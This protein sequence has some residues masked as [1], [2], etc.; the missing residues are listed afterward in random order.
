MEAGQGWSLRE[1]VIAVGVSLGA[2]FVLVELTK[3]N[4]N[5]LASQAIYTALALLL[6]SIFGSTGVALARLQPRSAL[7]GAVTAILS[8]LALGATVVSFWSGSRSLFGF[9]FEGTGGTVGGITV[10]LTIAASAICV[11]LATARPGEDSGT[12]LVRAG[13]ISAL[14]IFVGLA[15]LSILVDSVDIG[16]RVY[17]II[18]TVYIATTVVSLLLR[19][20]PT[21][22]DP[23]PVQ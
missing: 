21:D 4:V 6:F 11:L 9:G 7:F 3:S 10:I 18:A 2:V 16:S 13:G 8:P 19:L 1:T 15:I 23:V 22:E 14:A 20:L 5:E 17:V 12:R